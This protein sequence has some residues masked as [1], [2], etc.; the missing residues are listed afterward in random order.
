LSVGEAIAMPEAKPKPCVA[1]GT[2]DEMAIN[3]VCHAIR[4][5]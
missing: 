4:R 1:Q 3:V 5:Q 2:I